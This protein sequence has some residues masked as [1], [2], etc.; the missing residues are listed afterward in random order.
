MASDRCWCKRAFLS[1]VSICIEN[2]SFLYSAALLI[3]EQL[4]TFLEKT[5]L[6]HSREFCESWLK[7]FP[8]LRMSLEKMQIPLFLNQHWINCFFFTTPHTPTHHWSTLQII[9]WYRS[10]SISYELC[11]EKIVCMRGKTFLMHLKHNVV[12]LHLT[13]FSL[14]FPE[15]KNLWSVTVIIIIPISTSPRNH[16]YSDFPLASRWFFPQCSVK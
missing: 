10:V 4:F 1:F 5:S 7:S 6:H 14:A 15:N 3:L 16:S 12:A 8:Q 11:E 9:L 13:G 2:L